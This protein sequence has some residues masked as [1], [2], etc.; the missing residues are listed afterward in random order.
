MLN[1]SHFRD[2]I[3]RTLHTL[4]PKFETEAAVNLLLG[5]A[6]QESGLRHMRQIGGG[7]AL[8]FYQIEPATY[9]DLMKTYLF[10]S[11]WP[12][13]ALLASERW[14]RRRNYLEVVK[15]FE[16]PTPLM[17]QLEDNIAYQTAIARFIYWRVSEPL[18]EAD[19]LKELASYWKRHYNTRLGR[20]T[21]A[22]FILNYR[23]YVG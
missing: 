2:S 20:G 13:P 14:R 6:I 18:P 19:D 10:R 7:P 1:V 17:H 4:G 3:R 11:A 8:G 5:T 23:E 9:D 15:Q 22:A 16:A 12:R 21:E